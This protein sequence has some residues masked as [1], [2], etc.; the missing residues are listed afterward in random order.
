MLLTLFCS[1]FMHKN[2][3]ECN[4]RRLTGKCENWQWEAEHEKV[5]RT[6]DSQDSTYTSRGVCPSHEQELNADMELETRTSGVVD[7]LSEHLICHVLYLRL[8]AGDSSQQSLCDKEIKHLRWQI[9]HPEGSV[10]DWSSETFALIFYSYS[11]LLLFYHLRDVCWSD[12]CSLE[13]K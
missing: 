3:A 10:W 5:W 1:L 11:Y 7:R 4:K 12:L 2:T 13:V 9:A 8:H 6:P